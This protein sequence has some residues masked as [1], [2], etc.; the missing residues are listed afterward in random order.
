MGLANAVASCLPVLYAGILGRRTIFVVG[1]FA[2][3]VALFLCGLSILNE[4]HLTSFVMILVFIFCYQLSTG[5]FAWV[6]IPEICV[7]SATGFASSG[8]MISVTI[9]SFTFE[10]MINSELKVYGSIWFFAVITFIGFIFCLLVVRETRGLTDFEK[11]S[12]YT[13][14]SILDANNEVNGTEI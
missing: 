5:S 11:K 10:F 3:V 7:D 12:L 9:I 8:Q 4:W 14:K 6:Y 1:H 13:P 2:M